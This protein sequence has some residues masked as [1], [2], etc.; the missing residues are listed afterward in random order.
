MI[1][2]SGMVG[3]A[4]L[5]SLIPAMF[6]V[7]MFDAPG[8]TQNIALWVA[9]FSVLAFPVVAGASLVVAWLV[10]ASG[11]PW[12][13]L[14]CFLLPLLPLG[15]VIGGFMW[16]EVMQGGQFSPKAVQTAEPAG[17]LPSAE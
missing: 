16:I 15:G 4:A 3:L 10:F 9:F 5:A 13:A 1:A 7:M 17:D 11:R 6:S 8:S 12:P 14:L 2:L